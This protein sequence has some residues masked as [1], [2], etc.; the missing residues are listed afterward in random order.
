MQS[1]IQYCFS[2]LLWSLF[3]MIW[4]G[5]TL[6]LRTHELDHNS[7]GMSN[8]VTLGLNEHRWMLLK[9]IW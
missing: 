3:L 4:I 5:N 8:L 9:R 6:Q 7:R 2:L 1:I